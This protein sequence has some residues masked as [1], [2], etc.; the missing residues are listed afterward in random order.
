MMANEN[1]KKGEPHQNSQE[2]GKGFVIEIKGK[3]KAPLFP[4]ICGSNL[5]KGMQMCME[6]INEIRRG[7]GGNMKEIMKNQ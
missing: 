2:R 4:P 7:R 5:K 6:I 1:E 3:T